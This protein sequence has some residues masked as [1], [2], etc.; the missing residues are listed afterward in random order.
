MDKKPWESKTLWGALLML[1][2]LVLGYF[3]IEIGDA[4]AWV[5][6]IVGLIGVVT[7]IIGRFKAVKKI[8]VLS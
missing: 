4:S 1:V 2:S 6:S 5:D 3:K 7:V 8:K